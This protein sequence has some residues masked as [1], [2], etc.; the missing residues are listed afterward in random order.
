MPATFGDAERYI[1]GLFSRENH[2]LYDDT[3]YE[4]QFVGKPT[5][6][7]SE[8]KTDVLF[9]PHQ[10]E[11]SKSLRYHLKRKT[12]TFLKTKLTVSAQNFFSDLIGKTLYA[13]RQRRYIGSLKTDL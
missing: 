12:Q 8:P 9:L 3:N 10:Q 11:E 1:C 7:R 5:C 4:V 6:S 13:T 2:F